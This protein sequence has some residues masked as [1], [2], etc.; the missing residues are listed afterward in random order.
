MNCDDVRTHLSAF[1]DCALPAAQMA[2]IEAALTDC[3]ECQSEV[4]RMRAALALLDQAAPGAL[5]AG[6][7]SGFR[8]RLD[9]SRT[10][11]RRRRRLMAVGLAAAAG[12]ACWVLWSPA[13]PPETPPDAMIAH[14]GLLEDY[15][16]VEQLDAL[17]APESLDDIDVIATLDDLAGP[18]GER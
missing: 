1:V 11:A 15:A 8:A 5:P 12:L 6:F 16:V 10:Q 17:M 4:N 2:E 14:L 18:E 9:A 7:E 13:E 3:P